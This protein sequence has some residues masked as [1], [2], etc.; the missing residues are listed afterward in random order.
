[1]LNKKFKQ[2]VKLFVPYGLFPNV[3][4]NYINSF[5]KGEDK[6]FYE[7]NFY[8]RHAFI[9]LAINQFTNPNYLEIGVADNDVFNS[10]PLPMKNKFGVDPLEG[11][12]FRMTSD[13]FFSNNKI[14]FE[15][16]YIDGL[17]QYEQCQN[18]I[19]NSLKFL[20]DGGIIIIHDLLPK[21]YL[22]E[23]IPQKYYSW[24]GDVWK[25]AVE[26]SESNNIDFRIIN[27]D[28]GIGIAKPKG[29]YE[30]KKIPKLKD[31]NYENFLNYYNRLPIISCE[32]GL[33]FIKNNR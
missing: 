17:H 29:N 12:N 7:D 18:D 6:I 27:I 30:Y 31:M 19:I 2:F 4:K 10:I 33:K 1:M 3:I 8:K 16:I 24:T 28:M 13:K 5:L 23:H 11:G 20:N 22:E 26:L 9:N 32:D 21:N 25:V 15:V 14:K